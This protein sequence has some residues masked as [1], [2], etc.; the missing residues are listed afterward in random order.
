MLININDPRWQK[1]NSRMLYGEIDGV[2]IG[3]VLATN[4]NPNFPDT[5]AQR[6]RAE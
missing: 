3:V 2:K 4:S 5:Y 1:I 6:R